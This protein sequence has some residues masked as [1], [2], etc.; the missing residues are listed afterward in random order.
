M[1]SQ[2]KS[3]VLDLSSELFRILWK[4]RLTHPVMFCSQQLRNL[5]NGLKKEESYHS[6]LSVFF[7]KWLYG[8]YKK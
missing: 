1:I 4:Q 8:P 7:M 3:L 6:S 2:C 5:G